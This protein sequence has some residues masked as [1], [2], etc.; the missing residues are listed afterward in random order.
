MSEGHKK[1]T[2]LLDILETPCHCLI[3]RVWIK[4]KI[5][6]VIQRVEEKSLSGKKFESP[7]KSNFFP[8]ELFPPIFFGSYGSRGATTMAD[9]SF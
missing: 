5:D 7:K 6:N 9:H 2:L 8:L 1:I 4:R 3:Y